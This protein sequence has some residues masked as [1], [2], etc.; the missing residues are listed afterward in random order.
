[1][2]EQIKNEQTEPITQPVET[3]EKEG[4]KKGKSH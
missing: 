1:M 4:G 3:E 2:M